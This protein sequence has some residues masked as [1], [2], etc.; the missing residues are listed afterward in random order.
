MVLKFK[1]MKN[2]NNINEDKH[3]RS[4]QC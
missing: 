2:V 4:M 3:L 1:L